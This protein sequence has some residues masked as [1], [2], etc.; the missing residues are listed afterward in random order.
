MLLDTAPQPTYDGRGMEEL[1]VDRYSRNSN[2]Y[3]ILSPPTSGVGQRPSM[4][5]QAVANRPAYASTHTYDQTQ[6]HF[7]DNPS[8]RYHEHDSSTG[9]DPAEYFEPYEDYVEE[10]DFQEYDDNHRLGE[11]DKRFIDTPGRRPER[12]SINDDD[13]EFGNSNANLNTNSS[14]SSTPGDQS[15]LGSEPTGDGPSEPIGDG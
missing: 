6:S 4:L 7:Q 2:Y 14:S 11:R 3:S 1:E 5:D 10:E 9:Q 15:N 13:D 12:E 8:T